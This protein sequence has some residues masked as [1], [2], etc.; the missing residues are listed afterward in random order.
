MFQRT[1]AAVAGAASGEIALRS[2][3]AITRTFAVEAADD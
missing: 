1:F 2:V 3:S